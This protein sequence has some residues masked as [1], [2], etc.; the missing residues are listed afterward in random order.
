MSLTFQPR[1]HG[2]CDDCKTIWHWPKGRPALRVTKGEAYCPA[3]GQELRRTAAR[4]AKHLTKKEGVAGA[5]AAATIRR[6]VASRRPKVDATAA[7]LGEDEM[8]EDGGDPRL[9]PDP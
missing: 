5:S 2:R 7:A 3:C 8:L 9:H 1:S 6:R 4:L